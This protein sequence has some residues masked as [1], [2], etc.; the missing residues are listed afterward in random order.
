MPDTLPKFDNPPV[1][2]TVLSSQFGR[3]SKFRN[4]HAGVFWKSLGN[5]WPTVGDATRLE[6]TFERFG[7]ERIWGAFSGVRVL[8]SMEAQRTQIIR[9]DET[10]MI[11]VQD[12]RFVYNWRK[13]QDGGY[14][15]YETTHSEFGEVYG[16]FKQFVEMA[17]LGKIEENQWEVTYINHLVKGGLWNSLEDCTLIFPWFSFPDKYLSPDFVFAR[18]VMALPE[19]RGRLHVSMNFGRTS[20]TGPEAIILEL[21]A[22]GIASP[23]FSLDSGFTLGHEVIVNSFAAMTSEMA[24]KQWKR[25]Q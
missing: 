24:Q 21:T 13:S 16:Q 5:T 15:S 23:E 3:L 6:D 22:R 12:S 7:D 11:Q 14:P 18:W 9:S 20:A 2:E 10:R 19:Q 8:T 4:A 25:R 1:V 17:E